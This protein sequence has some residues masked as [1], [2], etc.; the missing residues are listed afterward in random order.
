MRSFAR[1]ALLVVALVGCGRRESLT[2]VA[3]ASVAPRPRSVE[4]LRPPAGAIADASAD[5][6]DGAPSLAADVD[7]RVARARDRFGADARIR[8]VGGVFVLVDVGEPSPLFEKA[9]ELIDRALPPLF[10]GRFSKRPAEGVT[11]LFFPTAK[12][13]AA[14]CHERY[15]DAGLVLGLYQPARRELAVDVSLGEAY[16]PS[17]THEVVHPLV[18]A[19]FPFAPLWLNEGIASLFEA[20]V[21]GDDGSIHGVP[22]NW[23]Y[24]DFLKPAFASPVERKLLRLDALFGMSTRTFR[25]GLDGAKGDAAKEIEGVHYALAR[26]VCAWLDAQGKLWPFYRAW[27]DG[28]DD[29]ETGERA[30]RSVMGG[31]P[32]ELNAAWAAWAR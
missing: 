18:A 20:P 24:D 27:R 11:A 15:P 21:F 1:R 22:R 12:P 28:F 17:F 32:K 30:F 14:Y 8:V 6:R 5:A 23:R 9:A 3:D 7:D 16:L 25:E 26:S 29:D 31:T 19:D 10:D 13:Y 2:P 4:G